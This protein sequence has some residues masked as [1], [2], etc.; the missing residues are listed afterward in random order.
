MNY[1][2]LTKV[3]FLC[4]MTVR[5]QLVALS[6]SAHAHAALDNN[7]CDRAHHTLS[8]NLGFLNRGA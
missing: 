6:Q 1:I 7:L 3:S 5:L 8:L 4:R 2:I